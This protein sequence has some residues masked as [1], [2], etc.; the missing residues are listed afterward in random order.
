MIGKIV[1]PDG[2]SMSYIPNVQMGRCAIDG[3]SLRGSEIKPMYDVLLIS[4]GRNIYL[5]RLVPTAGAFAQLEE[6]YVY[7]HPTGVYNI[8]YLS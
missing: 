1:R 8:E 4:W 7:K 3:T 2:I 5:Y 6:L